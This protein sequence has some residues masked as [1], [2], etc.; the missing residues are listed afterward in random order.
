VIYGTG[1]QQSTKGGGDKDGAVVQ[2]PAKA[3]DHATVPLFDD[4]EEDGGA[5]E[6]EEEDEPRPDL[7]GLLGNLGDLDGMDTARMLAL[8]GEAD[9]LDEE[10]KEALKERKFITGGWSS[11]DEEKK[12]K[13]DGG[14]E[15]AAEGEAPKKV[16][17]QEA[18]GKGA[19]AAAA[20]KAAADLEG[21]TDGVAIAH[22]VRI[23]LEDVPAACVA[24]FK[25]ERPIVLG[26]LLPGES[27]MGMVQAR[28]KRHR[29][30]PKLLKTGDAMLVSVGWRRFQTVPTFSLE[31]RG[32][33]RM[34]YLKYTLEHAHCTMTMH[35]PMMP[36][37]TGVLCFRSWEKV[38]HFRVCATGGVLESAPN[39]QIMKKLKLVGE[40]YKIFRNTSFVKNMF[41]TDLEVSK[42]MHAKVQTVSGIRGEIKK[43]EGTRGSFRATFE[44][45][46]LMSDL[47]VCKCWINVEPKQ[48]YHPVIDVAQW[49]PARLIGELRAAAGVPVPDNKDSQ[50]GGQFV[51]PERRFNPIRIPKTLQEALP[52]QFMSKGRERKK[53]AL[54]KKAAVVS[55]DRDRAINGLLTRLHT[56]RREK[57][58]IRTQA[59]AKKKA[60]K[61]KREQFI[62]DKRDVHTKEAKKK[63]Y[64]EQGKKLAKRQKALRLT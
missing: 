12:E 52:F 58:R 42:Y 27:R 38:G 26:G 34:R 7:S 22:F 45:R 35:A 55:S 54:R 53:D 43:A 2:Q 19:E 36:P 5:E 9:A 41:N 47:V 17:G 33:K 63:R 31:D 6:R 61:E 51:R 13:D 29:W 14:G 56:I 15:E 59:S 40:P 37:N 8:P 28:V 50:Y 48:F 10:A 60:A 39:F 64:Q 30:H 16:E 23:R 32:E 3:T 20:A 4:E 21:F 11:E 44:D 49:R 57:E 62:Q 18:A 24:E 1:K 46:I 25:R